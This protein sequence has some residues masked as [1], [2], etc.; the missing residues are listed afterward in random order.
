M[1]VAP[2]FRAGEQLNFEHIFHMRFLCMLIFSHFSKRISYVSISLTMKKMKIVIIGLSFISQQI[3]FNQKHKMI[4]YLK[5]FWSKKQNDPHADRIKLF[6]STL[7]SCR[8]CSNYDQFCPVSNLIYGNLK[9]NVFSDF[10]V[11]FCKA[12]LSLHYILKSFSLSRDVQVLQPKI[13]PF[14]V[15]FTM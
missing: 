14:K 4:K 12:S 6:R 2:D 13:F 5:Q 10:T 7:C 15:S 9:Q 11:L 1:C 8:R 3:F